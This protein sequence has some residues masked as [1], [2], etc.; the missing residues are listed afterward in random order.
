VIILIGITFAVLTWVLLYGRA[1]GI[2]GL[3]MFLGTLSYP[4][5]FVAVQRAA[6]RCG[7]LDNRLAP[8]PGSLILCLAK[9]SY[10]RK[11]SDLAKS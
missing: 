7:N 11:M 1:G 2:G 5:G 10:T 4:V 6:L 3:I 8:S 9:I